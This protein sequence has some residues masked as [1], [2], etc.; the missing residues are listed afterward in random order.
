VAIDAGVY[1]VLISS[2]LEPTWA[3]R[4]SFAAGALWGFFANKFFTFDKRSFALHEPVLFALVYTAG[5]FLNS[6]IHDGVMHV[7]G[8]K[9]LAFLGATGVST[10]TNFAGQKWIVF[11]TKCPTE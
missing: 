7:T 5:W 6:L 3:K 1:F 2:S 8:I 9:W 11:R 4:L 10:C